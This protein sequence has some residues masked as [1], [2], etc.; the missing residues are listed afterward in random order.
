MKTIKQV[1]KTFDPFQ[2]KYISREFQ[3]FGVHLS[4]VLHDNKHRS[5]YIIF[6]REIPR[7]ILEEALRFVWFDPYWPFYRGSFRASR[8]D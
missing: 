7:P 2:D 8:V 1:L 3:G 5:M 6:A 4:E